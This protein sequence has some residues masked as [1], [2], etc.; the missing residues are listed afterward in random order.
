MAAKESVR[1]IPRPSTERGNT[2]LGW[3]KSF[4]TFSVAAHPDPDHMQFGSLRVINEDRVS[5]RTGFGMHEHREFEIFSYIVNGELR[6]NDSM[7]NMEILKRGDLQMTSAGTGIRHSEYQH[8]EKPVHFLQVWC[9]PSQ[10]RLPP[11][12]YTRHFTDE[13]KT[14]KWAHIVAPHD[15]RE[16]GVS[17]EREAPGPAPV[18]SPLSLFATIL[19]Q[20]KIVSQKVERSKAYV[21]LIQT[22][23]YN[24]GEPEGASVKLTVAGKEQTLRE[25]DGLYVHFSQCTEVSVENVGDRTAEIVLFDLE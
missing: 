3:L 24:P 16:H 9:L 21:H 7:S 6:H 1:L 20:G 18:H 13:E 12:Y 23:G 22:S 11:T 15:D 2:D 4:H 10:Q 17:T 5:P 25:G 19:S 8:G 14:D